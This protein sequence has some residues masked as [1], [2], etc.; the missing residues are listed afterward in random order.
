MREDIDAG[1]IHRAKRGALRAAEDLAFN[2]L[3][4]GSRSWGELVL[5]EE[6]RRQERMDLVLLQLQNG[7]LALLPRPIAELRAHGKGKKNPWVRK[8]LA[9]GAAG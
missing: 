5:T 1:Q 4:D 7:H 3:M 6:G 9:K 2:R 8:L